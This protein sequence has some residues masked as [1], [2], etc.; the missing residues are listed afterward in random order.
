LVNRNLLL[1][2]CQKL[3]YCVQKYLMSRGSNF[4]SFNWIPDFSESEINEL[5]GEEFDSEDE[6]D[7]ET[8]L[9][10]VV[11]KGCWA[12]S[13]KRLTELVI[14]FCFRLVVTPKKNCKNT[15]THSLSHTHSHTNAGRQT[16]THCLSYFLSER[17]FS[18]SCQ[19]FSFS[20]LSPCFTGHFG[21]Q[22]C[23]KKIILCHGFL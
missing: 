19:C 12:D 8:F 10:M 22:Y 20:F 4:V 14:V 13:F 2:E 9:E 21:T 17:D 15:Y 5:I 7:F 16:D 6:V 11:G 3:K 23:N 1:K 18:F